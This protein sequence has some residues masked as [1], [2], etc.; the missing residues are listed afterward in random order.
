MANFSYIGE[1]EYKKNNG[2][3]DIDSVVNMTALTP[4]N[5]EF[6]DG[7]E[8]FADTYALE[9]KEDREVTSY[10]EILIERTGKTIR[11]INS[12]YIVLANE[13]KIVWI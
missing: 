9:M 7:K 8:Y 3:V 10:G 5:I 2:D 6:E 13:E 4:K 1:F 12:D 11:L